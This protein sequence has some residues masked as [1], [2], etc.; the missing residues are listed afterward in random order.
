[1]TRRRTSRRSLRRATSLG[2]TA[3]LLLVMGLLWV[4]QRVT[5]TDLGLS[6]TQTPTP[7]TER[8]L[9]ASGEWYELYFTAPKNPDTPEDHTGG[10]DE[11]VAQSLYGA[12]QSIDVAGYEIDLPLVA[13]A[14]VAAH[15]RGVVVRVV[16]DSDN[17]DEEQIGQM[18]DAGV[19]VVGDRRE[20]LMHDK[21]I[22]IDRARVWTGSMNYTVNGVYRNNNNLIKI[23]SGD[24]AQNYSAEFEEM[25]TRDEF[26]PTS[27]ADTPFP[28]LSLGGTPVENHF[29]PEDGVEPRLV[30]LVNSAQRSI[31][32]LAF[33][34]TS[35][36]IGDAMLAR[37][38]A[39]VTVQGVFERS[40]VASNGPASEYERLRAA[41]LDVRLDAN[42]YNMHHKVIV[43]DGQTVAF[44]S[45]NFSRNASE[46]NDENLLIV[47]NDDIASRFLTEFVKLYEQAE[48]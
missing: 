25:F 28:R 34:F 21:F 8:A 43:V 23:E 12:R 19:P 2:V 41:G 26:G 11:A 5:G 20:A 47:R 17:V 7:E 38:E 13:D 27:A 40:Q 30:E 45:Y 4:L 15:Q 6:P 29:S 44:G 32:F 22:V 9:P 36:P 14:L 42:Q 3:V 31:Y 24:L 16:T 33:S 48:R 35:D 37:A 39:G 1:M 10:L 46:Q 18:E